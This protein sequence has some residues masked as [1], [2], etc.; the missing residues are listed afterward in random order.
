MVARFM[1]STSSK[2]SLKGPEFTHP[3]RAS[4]PNLHDAYQI[5]NAPR[6]LM[7]NIKGKEHCHVTDRSLDVRHASAVPWQMGA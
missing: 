3:E 5:V 1:L 4:F 7:G 2:P 6:L